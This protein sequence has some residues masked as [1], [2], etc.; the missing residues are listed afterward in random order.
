MVLLVVVVVL[1]L[2]TRRMAII[3]DQTIELV[4]WHEK[5]KAINM[6]SGSL[7]TSEERAS[8]MEFFMKNVPEGLRFVCLREDVSTGEINPVYVREPGE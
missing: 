8:W 6:S 4:T 7:L 1:T 2:V 3:S 5:Y